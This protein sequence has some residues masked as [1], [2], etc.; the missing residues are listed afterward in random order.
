MRTV[1]ALAA[2]AALAACSDQQQPPT[3]PRSP[4]PRLGSSVGPTTD[5]NKVPQAK[6]TDQVGFTKVTIYQGTAVNVRRVK[7]VW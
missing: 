7:Q 1:F 3:S 4:D 2:V 5:G 6:P